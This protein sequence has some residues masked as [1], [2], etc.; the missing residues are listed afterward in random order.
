MPFLSFSYSA[1]RQ[2]ARNCA[3]ACMPLLRLLSAV[4]LRHTRGG[5]RREPAVLRRADCCCFGKPFGEGT[6]PG[7]KLRTAAKK[8]SRVVSECARD[9][10]WAAAGVAG[11]TWVRFFLLSASGHCPRVPKIET[12]NGILS[13]I[14]KTNAEITPWRSSELKAYCETARHKQEI[15]LSTTTHGQRFI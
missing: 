3:R 7:A 2:A 4:P 9:T 15:E 5:G 14:D 12:L 6:G 13:R 10:H 1:H 11:A 8:E